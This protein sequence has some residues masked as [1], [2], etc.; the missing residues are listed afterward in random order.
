[1]DFYPPIDWTKHPLHAAAFSANRSEL[2]RL[3]AE[4]ADVNE[5]LCLDVNG[6]QDVAGSPLH[7]ALRNCA[8]DEPGFAGG[9]NH[10][11]V[12]RQLLAAGANVRSR[13]R[14]EGTPLHDAAW[15]GR[16]HI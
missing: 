3:I 1:M 7:I 11:D 16:I 2:A 10:L 6:H 13:R 12:V 9:S 15:L 8:W 4:G 5:Q 14:W